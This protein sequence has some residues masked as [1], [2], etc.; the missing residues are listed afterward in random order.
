MTANKLDS[1]YN[2]HRP[3]ALRTK[4]A[5]TECFAA[6]S[7][8]VHGDVTER[9]ENSQKRKGGIASTSVEKHQL[10]SNT[11]IASKHPHPSTPSSIVESLTYLISSSSSVHCR[12]VVQYTT[13]EVSCCVASI[14][15]P[16]ST[17]QVSNR[18]HVTC[19]VCQ[20]LL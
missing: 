5:H 2:E 20:V 1:K 10:A 3:S 12:H 19:W 15:N 16:A 14:V 4:I 18:K 8:I 17:C 13:Q 6:F 9:K 7:S 11:K